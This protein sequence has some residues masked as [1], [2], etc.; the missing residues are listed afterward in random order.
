MLGKK[1]DLFQNVTKH[2]KEFQSRLA[3]GS[4]YWQTQKALPTWNDLAFA[5]N[6]SHWY[7]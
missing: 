6:V 3:W 7:P 5:G 1:K 4:F 2:N